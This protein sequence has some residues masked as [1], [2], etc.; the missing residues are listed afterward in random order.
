MTEFVSSLSSLNTLISS[1]RSNR[2][3]LDRVGQQVSSGKVSSDLADIDQRSNLLDLRETKAQTDAYVTAISIAKTRADAM[4]TSLTRLTNTLTTLANNLDQFNPNSVSF[5][6]TKPT[7][8]LGFTQNA[9]SSAISDVVSALNARQGDTYLF[10]GARYTQAPVDINKVT[11]TNTQQNSAPYTNAVVPGSISALGTAVAGTYPVAATTGTIHS[12]PDYDNA[13]TG[14]GNNDDPNNLAFNKQ[15]ITVEDQRRITFG[16]TAADPVFQD[17]FMALHAAQV[18]A[19]PPPAPFTAAD[20]RR[21]QWM[22]L[23]STTIKS[24]VNSIQSMQSKLGF[25]RADM[26]ATTDRHN[27]DSSNLQIS[28]SKIQD[29]DVAKASTDL[30]SIQTQFQ[31]SLTVTKTL[32]SLSLVNYLK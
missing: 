2:V 29:V 15:S 20:P 18:G 8:S 28:I 24:V 19:S 3:Q 32:L 22:Q 23:A 16:I 7:L 11:L 6:P 9:V 21:A 10:S 25:D 30:L 13:F 17:M 5:D 27:T 14:Y 31:G 4:D 26:Q 12:V 1:I